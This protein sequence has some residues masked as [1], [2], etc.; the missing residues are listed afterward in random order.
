VRKA[1]LLGLFLSTIILAVLD[2]SISVGAGDPPGTHEPSRAP[3][4]EP[5]ELLTIRTWCSSV[6]GACPN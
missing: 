1:H 6:A 2:G 5:R 3:Q 4:R